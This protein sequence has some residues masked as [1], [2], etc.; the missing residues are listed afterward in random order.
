M[1]EVSVAQNIVE[2]M[3]NIINQELN[4]FS[5]DGI[6]IASTDPS[7]I[8][9]TQH[10]GAQ[11]VLKTKKPIVIEYEGQYKGAKQ[12]INLPVIIDH[13]IIGVIGITGK[14]EE[15]QHFGE[16]I[17]Q[18]TEILILNNSARELLFNRRNINQNIIDYIMQ[19][20]SDEKHSIEILYNID[21]SL[22]RIAI[23]G[24][25]T[26]HKKLN[27]M[28]DFS[29]IYL[30]LEMLIGDQH[31]TF[32][33]IRGN[34][35]T[36]LYQTNSISFIE[37]LTSNIQQ[38]LK[39]KF[40][41]DFIFGTGSL[42]QNETQLKNSITQAKSALHWNRILNIK[43]ILHYEEMGY[44]IALNDIKTTSRLHY[45]QSVFKDQ[46][47]EEIKEIITLLMI[48]EKH[49]GSIQRCADDLYIHKNTVQYKLNKIK[50]D[51]GYSPRI[52]SDFFVL[53]LACILYLYSPEDP[54]N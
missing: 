26:L 41:L 38:M 54:I 11:I 16:I 47:D 31:Q 22:D 39:N 6:I 50:D 44:G 53:K 3:K 24:T 52:L 30:E 8:G 7:R 9:Q 37:R 18:M 10:E 29:S 42:A 14:R 5:V 4:F 13:Q 48:Y 40:N 33:D 36:I 19:P 51:T 2:R 27:L 17:K 23:V 49:N 1:I 35:I 28:D 46:T 43:S 32:F 21:F 15:V 34:I 20:N 45:L 25:P 12:G